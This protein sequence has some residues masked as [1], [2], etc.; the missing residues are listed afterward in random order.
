MLRREVMNIKDPH[1][2]MLKPFNEV[3]EGTFDE[4]EFPNLSR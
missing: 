4:F 1:V 3:F 2:V